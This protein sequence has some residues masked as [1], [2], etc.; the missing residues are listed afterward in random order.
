MDEP[1]HPSGL[2]EILD[3]TAQIYRARFLIFLGIATIPTAVL[4]LPCGLGALLV[5]WT[6]E[7]TKNPMAGAMAGLGFVALGMIALPIFAGA[8]ALANAAMSHAASR[9]I[10]GQ[11]TTIRDAYKAV[12]GRGW[13][14][15]GLYFIQILAVWGIPMVAWTILVFLTVALSALVRS[16]GLD[17][18]GF[19]VFA[20]FV[21]VAALVGFAIWMS[22]RLSVSYPAAVVE[23]IGPWT[24]VERSAKLT[25]GTKRRILLLYVLV[26][27]LNWILSAAITV[28]L[29]VAIYL[30]P[31][32][33]GP[34]HE[35]TAGTVVA[36]VIYGVMFLIQALTRPIYGIAQMLF[37]YDQ[38]IRQEA[39]DIEWMMLRAGLVVPPEP[40]PA[41]MPVPGVANSGPGGGADP[42][43]AAE[44]AAPDVAPVS[45]VALV[46]G[47]DP[48]S[49]VAPVSDADLTA[50]AQPAAYAEPAGPEP[51]VPESRG[52]DSRAAA[53]S[54]RG[55]I[56][57]TVAE[58]SPEAGVSES[59]HGPDSPAE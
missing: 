13:R 31:G 9:A 33:K 16:A 41:A 49:D 18:G 25:K 50:E 3:R 51:A 38:R 19:I 39:F 32:M 24:A 4:V 6:G 40:L 45:D 17:G 34:E 47:A 37:Y 11:K 22:L 48:V 54:P 35:Q 30:I 57:E 42:A 29:M 12:W 58:A 5:V 21:A 1:L 20:I 26:Y 59:A 28:P 7:H 43:E 27:V 10:L 52:Q 23:Q 15:V 2:S 44:P 36:F 55:L 46:S 14:Y 56:V 53:E 8:S